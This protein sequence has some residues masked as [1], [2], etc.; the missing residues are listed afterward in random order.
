[1]TSVSQPQFVLRCYIQYYDYNS[2]PVYYAD[3]PNGLVYG[4][5]L[6]NLNPLSNYFSKSFGTDG[7]ATDSGTYYDGSLV[8]EGD[9]VASASIQG[10]THQ[11]VKILPTSN[12][13]KVDCYVA[14]IDGYCVAMFASSAPTDQSNGLIFR[15]NEDFIPM[16]GSQYARDIMDSVSPTFITDIIGRFAVMNTKSQYVSINQVNTFTVGES[17][18]I[19][20]SGVFQK[21]AG[22][23]N[24]SDTVG[25]VTSKGIPSD[26]WFSFRP[27][28]KYFD[29]SLVPHDFFPTPQRIEQV[30]GSNVTL[31]GGMKLYINSISGDRA[32]DSSFLLY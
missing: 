24:I 5:S 28:G 6:T 30:S 23:L 22:S 21:S 10:K 31:I 27:S 26:N 2:Q 18:Y 15:V 9:W 20:S 14:D 19:D 4:L 7:L 32:G 12:S 16:L 8:K 13:N 3:Y 29:T 17:I 25:I 1:M 11:I